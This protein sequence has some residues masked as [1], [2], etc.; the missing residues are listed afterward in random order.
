MSGY[1]YYK[2]YKGNPKS[3]FFVTE[4]D[5]KASHSSFS[6]GENVKDLSKLVCIKLFS[7]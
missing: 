4:N 6:P 2:N 1:N 7:Y 3:N 5:L